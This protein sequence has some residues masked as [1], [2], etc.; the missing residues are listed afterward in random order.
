[1]ENSRHDDGMFPKIPL[2]PCGAKRTFEFQIMPSALHILN[3]DEF[4]NTAEATD[5]KDHTI[6]SMFQSSG[7]NWGVIAIY[8]CHNSCEVSNQEFVVVQKS[9]DEKPTLKKLIPIKDN[10][11]TP[12]DDDDDET[13]G[14]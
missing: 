10:M 2:C 9:N 4:N 8:S 12:Q 11:E 5:K 14:A 7:M 13:E 6:E 1:M 3:V